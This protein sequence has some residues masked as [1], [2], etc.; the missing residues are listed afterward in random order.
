MCTEG[1]WDRAQLSVWV[2][3]WVQRTRKRK[4]VAAIGEGLERCF[5]GKRITWLRELFVVGSFWGF[6]S[7][8][9]CTIRFR[10][11]RKSDPGALPAVALGRIC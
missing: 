9:Q 7:V 3:V 5:G 1:A 6:W 10:V 2:R 4:T 11:Q 8:A